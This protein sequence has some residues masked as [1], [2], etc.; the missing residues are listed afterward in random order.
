MSFSTAWCANALSICASCGLGDKV[1]RVEV[2][3]RYLLRGGAP[4]DGA[5]A[6]R[7]AA[8]VH[9]RMTEQVG[10][11]GVRGGVVGSGW[12]A[13]LHDKRGCVWV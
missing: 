3:R 12:G 11:G 9:D 1:D 4:L 10:V 2:S 6:A 7:F 13:R 8:L 5:A